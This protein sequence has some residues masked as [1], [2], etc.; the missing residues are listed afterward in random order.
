MEE[1]ILS[2]ELAVGTKLPSEGDLAA[3]YR[4]SRP[5]VRE[6]LARLRERG[7]IDTVNGSGTFVREPGTDHIADAFVR[8][9]RG[10][11]AVRD[12]I[13]ALYQARSLIE[14]EAARLATERADA[15]SIAAVEAQF[16]AMRAA[17][18]NEDGWSRADL[19]FHLAIA[20]ATGNPYFRTL[21]MPLATAILTAMHESL[22]APASRDAG[23]RAHA[24]IV[25]ALKA[26][27]ADRATDSMRRHLIDSEQR[28]GTVAGGA[29]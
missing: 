1:S 17:R 7:L 2:G 5:I 27:D 14:V 23:L 26:G 6:A 15:E 9:L 28:Y 20:D 13:A 25:D 8:H 10:S 22:R 18:D 11:G 19:G 16:D 4:V 21:L 12:R 24:E 3:S 29:A